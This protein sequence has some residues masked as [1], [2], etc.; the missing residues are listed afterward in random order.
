MINK[1][2]K[3]FWNAYRKFILIW[4]V[5]VLFI[6][7]SIILG[8]DK[9]IIALV[10]IL[11]GFLT[12]AFSG[13]IGMIGTIPAIG[14]MI[15]KIVTLPFFLLLNALAYLFT[16]FALRMGLKRDIVRARIISTA[17]L[18]GIVIGFILGRTF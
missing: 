12:Q 2:V 3:D 13:L 11:T 8:F 4:L 6:I 10:V 5:I 17:L 16:F 15:V 9:K 14:P 7:I 18:I 1:K